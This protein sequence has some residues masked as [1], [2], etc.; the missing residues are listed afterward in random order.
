[1]D[2]VL[3]IGIESNGDTLVY[4]NG[5]WGDENELPFVIT[6]PVHH[7]GIVHGI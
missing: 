6:I 5:N 3:H 1:M 7:W 4:T 2:M